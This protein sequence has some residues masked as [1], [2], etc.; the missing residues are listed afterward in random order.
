LTDDVQANN[1][2]FLKEVPEIS[3]DT[4]EVISPK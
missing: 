1:L 3:V 4:G 2:P